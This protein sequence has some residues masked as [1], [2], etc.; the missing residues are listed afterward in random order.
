MEKGHL[1][2]GEV[3]ELCAQAENKPTLKIINEDGNAFFILGK[4]RKTAKA[5]GWNKE[6]IDCF[7]AEARAGNY[8]NLLYVVQKYFDVV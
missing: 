4:A 7:M 6:Q 2:E 1:T 3:A 8:D 5:A